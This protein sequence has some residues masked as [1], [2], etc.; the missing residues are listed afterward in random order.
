MG[1]LET[2]QQEEVANVSPWADFVFVIW[3]RIRP[4][5]HLEMMSEA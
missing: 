5:P 3:Q 2:D 4:T 1:P